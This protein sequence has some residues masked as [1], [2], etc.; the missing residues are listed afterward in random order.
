MTAAN[1]APIAERGDLEARF[2][3]DP[4]F[5]DRVYGVFERVLTPD[6][7]MALT[8][9]SVFGKLWRAVCR[10]RQVQTS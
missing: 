10:A 1:L 9:N 4:A 3:S 7:I 2:R 8:Y 5:Q 6:M